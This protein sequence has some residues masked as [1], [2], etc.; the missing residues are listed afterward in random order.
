FRF[1]ATVRHQCIF[2]AVSSREFGERTS[3][4]FK[5]HVDAF[6]TGQNHN[7]SMVQCITIF[8][9]TRKVIPTPGFRHDSD[10]REQA[11]KEDPDL[12]ICIDVPKKLSRM[13]ELR[14]KLRQPE[15]KKNFLRRNAYTASPCNQFTLELDHHDNS[16][17]KCVGDCLG[18]KI[19]KAAAYDLNSLNIVSKL[20]KR[21]SCCNLTVA[22]ECLT[23]VL[24][25][26]LQQII[27]CDNVNELSLRISKVSCSDPRRVLFEIASCVRSFH[28]D[29]AL[30]ENVRPGSCYMF[31]LRDANWAGTIM[32]MFSR[33]LDKLYVENP[34]YP[35]YLRIDD[36]NVLKE[37]CLE[38]KHSTRNKI[39]NLP[40]MGKAIWLS[41]SCERSALEIDVNHD[42]FVKANYC[43]LTI[44]HSSREN[45]TW[46]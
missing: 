27:K 32:E 20:L 6:C 12:K 39:Q 43:Y 30:N 28:I 18:S 16:V 21:V 1:I 37:A 14:L 10:S 3:R 29:Q 42:Y 17:L 45:E 26:Q 8:T 31:G 23:D 46:C 9:S 13:F 19:V 34:N 7:I 44:R 41:T 11:F 5:Q 15:F 40:S 38:R 2:F 35:R 22:F 36:A 4:L 25:C 24:F 33:K